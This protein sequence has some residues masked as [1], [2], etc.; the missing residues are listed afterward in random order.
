M[1]S[2]KEIIDKKRER[3]FLNNGDKEIRQFM[4]A[5]VKEI[6]AK[7]LAEAMPKII[8]DA[9]A[10]VQDE[11]DRLTKDVQRGDTGEQGEVGPVGP[12]GAS[13][14]QG[15]AGEHGPQGYAGLDGKEGAPGEKGESGKPGKDGSP[16][17]AEQ[18]TTKLNT[19]TESLDIG[20]IRGL[21]KWMNTLQRSFKDIH[22]GG[23]SGG[24]MGNALHESFNIN[25]STTF[26]E[27]ST[28]IAAG[29]FAVWAYYQGQMIAR[30][31]AYTMSGSKRLNLLFTPQ[32]NT[33]IDVIYIRT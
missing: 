28:N 2:A 16:D 6:T 12:R 21:T 19:L 15:S 23:K 31:S 22:G 8:A 32:D 7:T 9:S 25:S 20:V 27:I 18:I 13:G 5:R 24:G 17:T 1:P 29:G 26:I 14:V 30:G 3:D 10:Q 33:V 11:I 4:D